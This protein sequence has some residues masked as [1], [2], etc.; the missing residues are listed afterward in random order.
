MTFENSNTV[1][2]IQM[3]KR[4]FALLVGVPIALLY[5][6][7]LGEYIDNL[8]GISRQILSLTLV[9]F[10]LGFYFYHIFVKSSYLYYSDDQA[11]VIIRFYKLN[12][13]DSKKNSYEIPKTQ[14]EGYK[15]KKSFFNLCE[16]VN[17]YRNMSG[18]VAQYPP[19]SISS[20]NIAE[21]QKLFKAL[22]NYSQKQK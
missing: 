1:I 3:Q 6:T 22:S 11:K 2:R 17:V 9:A 16:E 12:P 19:F 10:Y 21:K 18:N 5:A 7:E 14:F 20:L 13:F 15:T 4:I 8:T